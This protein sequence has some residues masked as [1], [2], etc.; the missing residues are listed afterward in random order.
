[1]KAHGGN[2]PALRRVIWNVERYRGK[3]L[4]LRV[5]DRSS[6]AWGHVTL[7][8]VSCEGALVTDE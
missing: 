5:V 4:F 3:R 6:G 1:M 7:D 2:G 8:D